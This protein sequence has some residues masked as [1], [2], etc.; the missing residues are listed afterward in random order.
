MSES[1]KHLKLDEAI[2]SLQQV[3][4][5]LEKLLSDVTMKNNEEPKA[6]KNGIKSLEGL[7]DYGPGRIAKMREEAL[8]IIDEIHTALFVDMKNC[9]DV[10]SQPSG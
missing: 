1:D 6:E 2:E 10:V 4:D 8:K 5:N 9:P 7:L 3:V